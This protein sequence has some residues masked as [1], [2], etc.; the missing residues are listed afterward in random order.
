MKFQNINKS[1]FRGTFKNLFTF[2]NTFYL[3]EK[4]TYSKMNI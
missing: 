2:L 4:K 3:K 1:I